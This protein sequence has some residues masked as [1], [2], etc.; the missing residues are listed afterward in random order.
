MSAFEATKH[1]CYAALLMVCA[2][3]AAQAATLYVHCGASSGLNSINA[4]LKALNNSEDRGPTTINVSGACHENIVIQNMDRLTIAGSNGASITDASGDTAD[5][6]DI[7]NSTAT[8]TGMTIDGLTGVNYDTST[9]SRDRIAR[10]W[11]TRFKVVGTRS[12][13]ITHHRQ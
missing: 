9:A 2:S 4:A 3:A 13:F 11:G 10:S 1:A 6:V 12:A 5:V 7:R 8:I